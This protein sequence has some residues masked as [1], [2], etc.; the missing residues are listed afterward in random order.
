M[1][2]LLMGIIFLL[3]L[4]AIVAFVYFAMSNK[5]GGSAESSE[6]EVVSMLFCPSDLMPGGGE[7]TPPSDPEHEKKEDG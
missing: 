6:K 2:F 4:V 5:R 3:S 1:V 7:K